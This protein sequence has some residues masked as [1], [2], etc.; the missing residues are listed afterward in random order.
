[1]RTNESIARTTQIMLK[2]GLLVEYA[3][4]AWMTVEA[5]GSIYAGAAAGSLA[6]L[7]FGSDSIVELLS[8]LAVVKHLRLEKCGKG[9]EEMTKRIEK[10]TVLLLLLLIPI[11]TSGTLYAYWT[12]VQPESSILGIIIAVAAIAIMPILWFEKRR[13]GRTAKC[14]PLI[15]DSTESATCLS[16]SVALLVGLAANLIWKAWWV[17]YAATAVILIFLT[18]EATESAREMRKESQ[19]GMF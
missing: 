18:R 19:R 14:L 9:S 13:L 12:G 6:L 2:R 7:A 16:M 11:I 5:A 10:A 8:S 17:D 1:M 3:S 15:V 4:L